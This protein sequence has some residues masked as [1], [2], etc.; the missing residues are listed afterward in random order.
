MSE[1]DSGSIPDDRAKYVPVAQLV[2]HWIENSGV[3]GSIPSGYTK[4]SSLTGKA[5]PCHG[6]GC[7]FDSRLLCQYVGE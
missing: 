5:S 1:G 7:G 3:E 2:E 4:S 6:E